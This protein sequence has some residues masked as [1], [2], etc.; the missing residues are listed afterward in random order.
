MVFFRGALGQDAVIDRAS[1]VT[2]YTCAENAAK[3]IEETLCAV[4][5]IRETLERRGQSPVP[6]RSAAQAF[7]SNWESEAYRK[8]V[9]SG[10]KAE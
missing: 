3:T 5:F 10:K 4:V 8:A 6:M 2:A 7:I 9:G 1:G